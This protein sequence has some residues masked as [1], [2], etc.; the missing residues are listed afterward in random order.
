[1]VNHRPVTE[2]T[3]TVFDGDQIQTSDH[4]AARVSAPGLSVYLPANSC[5]KYRGNEF[6]MCS[7]GSVD[8][9]AMRP[10][11][12][13]YREKDLVVSSASPDSAFSVSLAGRDLRVGISKGYA[14]VAHSGSV[15]EKLASGSS[16]SFAGLGC[17]LGAVSVP[18][19]L[20]RTAITTAPA[21][22]SAAVIKA[23]HR[24]PLSSITP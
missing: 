2:L 16:K 6:E 24:A 12:V 15:L 11:S 3:S 22:I 17:S 18:A 23:E 8:I 19:S 21:A 4:A 20:G 1:M 14:E 10:A 9:I 13:I 5:L 7:C